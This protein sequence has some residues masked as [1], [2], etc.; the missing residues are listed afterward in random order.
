M[1]DTHL[2][3]PMPTAIE[4]NCTMASLFRNAA[5]CHGDR[6]AIIAGNLRISHAN[7]DLRSD[8]VAQTLLNIGIGRDSIICTL[9]P[10]G[11]A[12]TELLLATAKLGATVL[13]LNWRLAPGEIEYIISDAQPN[14][15]FASRRFESLAHGVGESTE[16]VWVADGLEDGAGEALGLEEV[17]PR[18]CRNHTVLSN[19]RWYTLYTSGTTGRPKGCQHS[20]GGYY[21]HSLATIGKAQLRETDCLLHN[22][23]LFHVG[24]LSLFL[25]TLVAGGSVV[26]QNGSPMDVEDVLS[27]AVA[28]RAT[29]MILYPMV[30]EDLIKLRSD[31]NLRLN[32]RLVQSGGGMFDID[33]LT[34]VQKDLGVDLLLGYGQS[35][36]GGFICYATFDEQL[37]NPRSAGYPLPIWSTRIVDSEGSELPVGEEGELLIRGPGMTAGY[38]N[39]EEA[40]RATLAG[41]WLHTGDIFTREDDGKL[42]FCGR[43]KELVKTGGENVYPAEVEQVLIQHPKVAD[44]CVVGVPDKRWGEAVKACVVLETAS[45]LTPR[46][47]ADWCRERLAGYKKPRYVEFIAEI[48]R[49]WQGKISRS[50]LSR[51]PVSEEQATGG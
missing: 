24:G 11:L 38:L 26:F 42:T 2:E 15:C 46:E 23:P 39:L 34:R 32:L 21:I 18:L 37:S 13:A 25:S 22:S 3:R 6:P 27:H 28:E 43:I 41:G 48:P 30:A 19:D 12:M 10:D 4:H 20:Q 14:L 35:E 49:N 5:A 40:T 50:E 47:L 33:L 7:L 29:L 8:Q 36:A 45:E 16:I 44:C 9:L 17:S 51:R 31:R 1:T